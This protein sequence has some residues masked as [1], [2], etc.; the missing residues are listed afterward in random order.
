MLFIQKNQISSII[1]QAK[2]MKQSTFYKNLKKRWIEY[3]F[4]RQGYI[5]FLD[6]NKQKKVEC[7]YYINQNNKID[8]A[9]ASGKGLK[10]VYK[11]IDGKHEEKIVIRIIMAASALMEHILVQHNT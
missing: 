1:F 10:V 5:F 11:L 9:F 6:K 2:K 3:I 4:N 8:E 7:S